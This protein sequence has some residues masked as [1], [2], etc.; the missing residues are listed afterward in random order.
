DT[1]NITN[2]KLTGDATFG[3]GGAVANLNNARMT[4]ALTLGSA[5]GSLSFTNGTIYNGAITRSGAGPMSLTVNNSTMN[6]LGDGTLNLTSMSL[7][8]SAKVGLIVDNARVT[9]NTPIYNVVG[10]ADIGANTVFTPIFSQFSAQPFTLR[11]LNA[12]TLNLGGPVSS[13]LNANSPYIYDVQLVQPNANAIDLVLDVKTASELGLNTREASAYGAVLNLLGEDDNLGAALTS[14]ATE[15]E[16]LRGWADLMPGSDAAVMRVLSSN[17]TA[18]FGATAHR[19]DLI[20]NKPDAPGGAWVEEFGVYHTTDETSRSLGVDGG[21]FGVA[22]GI[23]VLSNGAALIGAYAALESAELE[24][25]GRT[26]APLNVAQTSF[27]LYGGWVNGPLAINGAAS[28]GFVD[29]TSDRQIAVGGLTDRLRAEWNGQSYTAAARATYT[30]PLGWIDVKPYLAADYIGFKQDSYSETA[31]TYDNL[32]ITAGDS[33][34]N[35]ATASYGLALIGNL[36]SDDA[37]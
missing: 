13:M 8:N 33:D 24:E 10:T 6:N 22:A 21:G 12:T 3:G 1:L 25:G 36:G 11:V 9:G 31:T 28:Y 20:A 4:G 14:I 32:A 23:D 27:G 30:V 29:F 37:F 7:T 16:F 35:L 34:A 2:G 18:A 26:S 15:G 19:L 5:N 17:A